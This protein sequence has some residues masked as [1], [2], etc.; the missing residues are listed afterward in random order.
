MWENRPVMYH[1]I[2]AVA[3]ALAIC[4][5]AISERIEE[6]PATFLEDVPRESALAGVSFQHAWRNP[7]PAR[8]AFETLY[9]APVRTGLLPSEM[10]RRSL[11]V[12]VRSESSFARRVHE[13]ALFLEEELLA[14]LRADPPGPLELTNDPTHTSV[15]LEI[16]LTEVVLARPTMHAAALAAPLPGVELALSTIDDPHL[17]FAARL[18]APNGHLLATVADRRF[19]P[20]RVVD[21]NKLTL[22]SSGREI[23]RE[24]AQ[25]LA[26]L[27]K[28]P[29]THQGT[30]RLPISISPW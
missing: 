1:P 15:I 11:S 14:A 22:T 13:L 19:P 7:V 5:C 3:V 6:L 12:W 9:V 30:R 25:E 17:S 21:L 16:A 28:H 18:T 24:W 2:I 29:D 10:W 27:L 20:I 26:P 8:R 23:V 4:G